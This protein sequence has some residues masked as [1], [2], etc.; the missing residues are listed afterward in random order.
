MRKLFPFLCMLLLADAGCKKN[1]SAWYA[2]SFL[3]SINGSPTLPVDFTGPIDQMTCEQSY[4]T[5]GPAKISRWT[6]SFHSTLNNNAFNLTIPSTDSSNT[7]PIGQPLSF[8]AS[9]NTPT[10][11]EFE[12]SVLY[13]GNT[14]SSSDSGAFT[15]TFSLFDKKTTANFTGSIYGPTGTYIITEGSFTGIPI[16]YAN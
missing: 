11:Q 2:A 16:T 4:F 6:F 13:G 9:R 8:I 1:T 10:P 3:G 5:G 7:M 14:F 12:L 15:I